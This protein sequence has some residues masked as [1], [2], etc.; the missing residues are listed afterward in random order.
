MRPIPSLFVATAMAILPLSAF[1]QTATAPVT[2]AA[3]AGMT[4][5]V[6]T[7]PAPVIGKSTTKTA[8]AVI[9]PAKP[10]VKT[11]APASKTEIHSMN[12]VNP[13]RAKTSAPAKTAEP[14]KS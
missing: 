3:P 2:D 8:T 7:A 14:A 12:T 1:A 9:Q 11:A 5:T 4:S 6:P 10:D 13:H